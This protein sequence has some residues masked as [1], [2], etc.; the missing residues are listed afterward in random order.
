[1]LAAEPLPAALVHD[2]QRAV[3]ACPKLA[4]RLTQAPR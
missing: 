1:L 2:A 4:L 3:A